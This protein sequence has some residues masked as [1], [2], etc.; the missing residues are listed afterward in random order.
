MKLNLWKINYFEW[1]FVV[2]QGFSTLI[3]DA[4]FKHADKSAKRDAT[5]ILLKQ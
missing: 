2:N 3:S 4:V 5:E 1:N